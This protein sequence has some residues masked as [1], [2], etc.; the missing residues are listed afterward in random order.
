MIS[1]ENHTLNCYQFNK[2]RKL[3]ELRS[4]PILLHR[5]HCVKNRDKLKF[6]L[7]FSIRGMLG[8]TVLVTGTVGN[9]IAYELKQ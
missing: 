2:S 7:V 9:V 3:F 8:A 1:K 5:F 4:P 6:L